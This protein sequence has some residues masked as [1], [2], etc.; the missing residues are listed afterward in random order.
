METQKYAININLYRAITSTK[1]KDSNLFVS[2]ILL[3]INGHYRKS[4][5]GKKAKTTT[6]TTKKQNKK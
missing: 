5:K 4:N 3:F 6:T 1:M 2:V